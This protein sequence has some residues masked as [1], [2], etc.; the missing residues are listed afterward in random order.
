MKKNAIRGFIVMVICLVLYHLLAFLIPFEHTTVFWLAY[1]FTLAAFVVAGVAVY[2]A[3]YRGDSAKSQFYGFPIA[4]IGTA[5]WILQLGLGLVSMALGA[6]I[7]EWIAILVFVFMLG[8]ALIGI[9]SA[10]AIRD[11]IQQQDSKLRDSVSVMRSLQSKLHQ[12]AAQCDGQE[13]AAAVQKLEEELRYSDP[14]SGPA[15]AEI[16]ADL[17]AAVDELQQAVVDGDT[18][19]IHQL[20]RKAMALLGERNRL[21]KLNK[22]C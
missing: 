15:L 4:R 16:E 22:G 8:A 5:Y 21:C 14:V 9:I 19:S 11:D 18:A 20:C 1:G 13:A 17:G 6:W 3:S 2:L 7:A 12:M 10:D